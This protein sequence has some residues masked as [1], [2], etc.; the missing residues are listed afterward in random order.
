MGPGIWRGWRVRLGDAPRL[1]VTKAHTRVKRRRVEFP[2][3]FGQ[4]PSM[5]ISE[6]RRNYSSQ[7]LV[8]EDLRED[9]IAQFQFWFE[10]AVE[11]RLLEPNAMSL[12]TVGADGRPTLRTVLLK[13]FDSRGFVFFTNFESTKARQIGE[14]PNV[15]LLF[16]WIALERQVNITGT[17][18][19]ISSAESLKYFLKRPVESQLGAWASRQS[20]ILESRKLLE[21]KW[22]EVRRKVSEGKGPLPSFWGGY[23][24]APRTIEFWQGRASRL[25]DRFLYA[26]QPDRTWKIDRLSP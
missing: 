14:N 9:P 2:V 4:H 25:H 3:G 15:A 17:A 6:L 11:A 19:R 7:G 5:D 23:R 1:G 8:R 16:P 10:Q 12:A 21:M 20:T 18:E 24:V 13:E 26:R 22:A